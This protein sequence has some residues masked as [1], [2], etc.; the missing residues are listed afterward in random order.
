M[1]SRSADP[2]VSLA[3]VTLTFT[4]V[5][6]PPLA[7]CEEDAPA[8]CAGAVA[9][10]NRP[11]ITAAAVGSATSAATKPRVLGF[12]GPSS[13]TGPKWRGMV[14]RPPRGVKPPLFTQGPSWAV[15][16]HGSAEK[17]AGC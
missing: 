7:G 16:S 8:R 11:G 15:W 13:G 4:R 5:A 12:K 14:A 1:A 17:E 9:P 10:A 6:V 2:G 3:V